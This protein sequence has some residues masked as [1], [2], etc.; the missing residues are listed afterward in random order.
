[1]VRRRRLARAADIHSAHALTQAVPARLPGRLTSCALVYESGNSTTTRQRHALPERPG[2][3]GRWRQ[4]A[5]PDERRFMSALVC[6]DE[7]SLVERADAAQEVEL[8]AEMRP[9]HLRA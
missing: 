5:S 7:L 9:H 2:K 3:S 1:M 4:G 6:V 8:V